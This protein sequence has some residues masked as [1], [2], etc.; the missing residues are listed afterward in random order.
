MGAFSADDANWSPRQVDVRVRLLGPIRLSW[1]GQEVALESRPAK[2]LVALLA[3]RRG[4]WSRAAITAQIWPDAG[5]G[6]PARVRQALWLVRRGLARA[7]A[8]PRAVLATSGD[9]IGFDPG[10]SAEI[11]VA[12]FE[13]QLREQPPRIEAA[14]RLYGGDLAEELALDC[15]AVRRETLADMYEDALAAVAKE[16]LDGNDLDGARCAA[17]ELL[18]RDPLRE[19]GHAILIEAYGIEGSRSQAHRQ[20]A[21][22]R[23]MLMSELAA[24]P[25]PETEAAYR[26]AM[27]RTQA[28]SAER[29]ASSAP[30]VYAS[31]L[32]GARSARDRGRDGHFDPSARRD[33]LT[34]LGRRTNVVQRKLAPTDRHQID[35][36]LE[37]EVPEV[38][39]GVAHVDID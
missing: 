31:A 16:R 10:V 13:A 12:R 2:A 27:A 37:G 6:P 29:V 5:Y 7:G 26:V 23:A 9:T 25:L 34:W 4:P 17:I 8:D 22:L 28:R 19:E 35:W 20:Y 39:E 32:T 14:L 15:L 3:V 11:D 30:E 38:D 24:D 33:E 36:T 1:R 21:R 18:E